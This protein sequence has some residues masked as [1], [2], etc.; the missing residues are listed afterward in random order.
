LRPALGDRPIRVEL[1]PDLPLLELDAVLMERV[2]CNLIE[3]AAK[4]SPAGTSID[5][6]AKRREEVFE[7]RVSDRGCGFPADKA[8]LFGM[9]VR[10]AGESS[11]P[12]VG[13]G[14]AI[15]RA[16]MEAHGGT[17]EALDREGGGACVLL[18]LPVGNPP[19]VEEEEAS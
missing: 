13:L 15:C 7:L 4:Y 3:N 17:I 19:P 8:A 1:A 11:K 9:F 5:I 18:T 16:I 6:D 14:L 2:F 10:S 12:G